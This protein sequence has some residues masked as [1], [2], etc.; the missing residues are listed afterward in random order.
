MGEKTAAPLPSFTARIATSFL[1][2]IR[3]HDPTGCREHCHEWPRCSESQSRKRISES[4]GR[5]NCQVFR[6][7][8]SSPKRIGTQLFDFMPPL[9]RNDSLPPHKSRIEQSYFRREFSSAVRTVLARRCCRP[10]PPRD[11]FTL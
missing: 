6:K 7:G 10:T 11:R 9:P 2:R 1:P 4:T 3:S 5:R 8:Q